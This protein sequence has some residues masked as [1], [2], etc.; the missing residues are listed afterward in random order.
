MSPAS[1]GRRRFC[2]GRSDRYRRV[3]FVVFLLVWFVLIMAVA[4]IA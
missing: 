3:E 4:V 2:A 1:E